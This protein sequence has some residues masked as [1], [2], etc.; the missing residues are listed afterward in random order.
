[1]LRICHSFV[2]IY[3]D[4]RISW[5]QAVAQI[6][7]DFAC[8]A[9]KVPALICQ[10]IDTEDKRAKKIAMCELAW[11]GR[12]M[13]AN[14][15]PIRF[16]DLGDLQRQLMIEECIFDGFEK[17]AMK[18]C[19][20]L[21]KLSEE[22]RKAH[23]NSLSRIAHAVRTAHGRQVLNEAPDCDCLMCAEWHSA[24]V[25]ELWEQ[26]KEENRRRELERK[27][28]KPLRPT[29]IYLVL[30]ERTGYIKI[31][32]A[33]NPSERERTL[34]SENPQVAMLFCSPADAELE[35]ELHQE[36]AQY[37]IRGEW[38]K[39]SENHIEHIKKRALNA[40]R[41]LAQ[42]SVREQIL[43]SSPDSVEVRVCNAERA[44]QL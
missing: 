22:K 21:L 9:E 8:C 44:V 2:R 43:I 28:P 25:Q 18:Y 38:F 41:A 34:Q 23:H 3:A 20:W 13:S 10:Y 29:F 27:K 40:D 24:A 15:I 33:R 7:Q 32:R 19:R 6:K 16:E 37:R 35:R 39:L 12:Y 17:Q 4:R 30:D 11:E 31:G 14:S 42:K 1:M 36:F 5:V 26:A